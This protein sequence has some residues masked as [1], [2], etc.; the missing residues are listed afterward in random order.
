MKSLNKQDPNTYKMKHSISLIIIIAIASIF[1]FLMFLIMAINHDDVGFI[2]TFMFFLLSVFMIYLPFSMSYS[3]TYDD[4]M[5]GIKGLFRTER[6]IQW[7]EVK[8]I[9]GK[10]WSNGFDL[11]DSHGNKLM[12][13]DGNLKNFQHFIETLLDKC[14]Y[15]FRTPLDQ[16]LKSNPVYNSAYLLGSILISLV[17]IWVMRSDLSLTVWM[18]SGAITIFG[19]LIFLFAIREITPKKDCLLMRSLARRIEFPIKEIKNVQ[20]VTINMRQ[21]MISTGQKLYTTT[22]IPI[23]GRKR[24]IKLLGMNDVILFLYLHNWFE[25]NRQS[26]NSQ[27]DL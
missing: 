21:Y 25:E 8:A 18:I 26:L 23:K 5:I 12:P 17:I 3:I 7:N 24:S 2:I 13:I 9:K 6:S 19:I 27:P 16:P 14:P 4:T 10:T 20:L 1:I 15:L 11:T 22:L